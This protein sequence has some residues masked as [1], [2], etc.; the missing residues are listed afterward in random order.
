MSILIESCNE[1]LYEGVMNSMPLCEADENG[2]KKSLWQKVKD[3]FK[4]IWNWIKDKV[5]ALFGKKKKSDEEKLKELEVLLKDSKR[6]SSPGFKEY[7]NE[8]KSG[9]YSKKLADALKLLE[10]DDDASREKLERELSL[11]EETLDMGADDVSKEFVLRNLDDIKLYNELFKDLENEIKEMEKITKKAVD[12]I[13]KSIPEANSDLLKRY[14]NILPKAISK[15][16]ILLRTAILDRSI[17]LA[18]SEE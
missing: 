8:I 11:A 7:C 12:S 14:S 16:I 15:S 10:K 17:K 5:L 4:K 3:F 2:D 13:G 1:Y 6:P 18:K 9:M